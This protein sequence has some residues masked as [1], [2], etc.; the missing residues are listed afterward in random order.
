MPQIAHYLHMLQHR[1]TKAPLG[2]LGECRMGRGQGPGCSPRPERR[3]LGF[4][5]EHRTRTLVRP[6]PPASRALANKR[7][8]VGR[9]S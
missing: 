2:A 8:P 6:Q 1:A 3:R 9:P 4:W 5:E 7:E